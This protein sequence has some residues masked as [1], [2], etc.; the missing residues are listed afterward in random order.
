MSKAKWILISGGAGF[1]GR[2]VT[3]KLQ[4]EGYLVRWLDCFDPQVHGHWQGDLPPYWQEADD[5][6]VG[7]V[8]HL[9]VWHKALSG[10]EVVIHL[11]AQTGTGQSMYQISRYTDV[12]IQGT[13]MLWEAIASHVRSVKKVVIASSRA[14]YGEGQYLCDSGCGQ[15]VPLSRSE[16]QLSKAMWE[17]VCPQCHGPI[18]AEET[19]E[20][21][22]P[23]PASLYACSKLAQE[24]ISLTM[25]RALRI[26][27]FV[28]RF[29]NVYGPGQSLCNP[30]TGIL[31]VFSNLMRQDL[32]VN[33]FEDGNQSRDFVY[34]HDI[35]QT[36]LW[37]IHSQSLQQ[38]V[39]VGSGKRITVLNLAKL[40]KR[41]WG[42]R[43]S[44]A[45]TGH[46]RVGD[47]RH[48]WASTELF[49]K[50]Y[51][52]W[53]FLGIDEGVRSFVDWAKRQNVFKDQTSIEIEELRK[54][55]LGSYSV[56]SAGQ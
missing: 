47:I 8:R 16:P 45:I 1:I 27:V 51:P 32:P 25:G 19:M 46:F 42:S 38:V 3:R 6:V 9:D 41:E 18:E 34:V 21:T 50:T 26:P 49:Q 53:D 12:N 4:N 54:R 35:A 13:S 10:I 7:D 43:S 36:C 44:L 56:T 30:Y 31:S 2:H 39:N 37:A 28:L 11:A 22:R 23:S 15:V 24:Q 17:P 55:K 20:A 14:I 40:L 33:I 29:Q 48:N 52:K 5:I